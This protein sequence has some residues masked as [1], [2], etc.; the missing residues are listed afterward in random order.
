MCFFERD[1]YLFRQ[2]KNILAIAGV[3]H[4][5]SGETVVVEINRDN[6]GRCIESIGMF[7]W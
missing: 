6:K 3:F 2:L 1:D 7:S 4:I 5:V